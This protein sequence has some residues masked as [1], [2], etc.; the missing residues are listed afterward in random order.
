M[1]TRLNLA[2][3]ILSLVGLAISIYLTLYHYFPSVPLVCQTSSLINCANVLNS[4][5]A[6]IFGFPVALYGIIFFMVELFF[7]FA[8]KKGITLF[9][10]NIIGLGFVFYFLYSEYEVGSICEY[11]TMVHIIVIAL[12]ISSLYLFLKEDERK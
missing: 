12:L 9:V 5:Y 10:W 6:F 3:I 4:Q 7:L 8:Q 11:C 1:G 2:M